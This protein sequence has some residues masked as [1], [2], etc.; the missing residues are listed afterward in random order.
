MDE[1]LG[2][3]LARLRTAAG[4][5]AAQVIEQLAV[6]RSTLYAWEADRFPPEPER[7]GELLTLYGADERQ[8][9]EAWELRARPRTPVQAVS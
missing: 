3:L 9:L 7:L 2:A 4:M 1:T 8:R 5:T 6:G